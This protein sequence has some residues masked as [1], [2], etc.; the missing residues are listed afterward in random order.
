MDKRGR[1]RG[2][3]RERVSRFTVENLLSH[4]TEKNRKGAFLCSRKFL[5]SEKFMDRRGREVASRFS[6][7]NS[8]SHSTKIYRRGTFL[9]FRK[10]LVPIDSMD[11]RGRGEEGSITIHSRKF[12]VS[13]YVRNSHRNPSEFQKNSGIEKLQR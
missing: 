7:E 2:R 6:V 12:A 5:L 4:S 3:G 8:L 11:K 9:C 13:K 10:F 1:G